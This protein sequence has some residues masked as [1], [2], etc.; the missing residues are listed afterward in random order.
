MMRWRRIRGI[1]QWII[2]N[3]DEEM[4]GRLYDLIR[5]P[6]TKEAEV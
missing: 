3:L 1:V 6:H 4:I 2:S 5:S